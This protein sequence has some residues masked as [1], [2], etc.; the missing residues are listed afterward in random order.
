M[1]KFKNLIII[2]LSV[3]VIVGCT[4]NKET[5][6]KDGILSIGVIQFASHP[7][8]DQAFEGFKEGLSDL[9]LVEGEDFRIE[10]QNAQG[11]TATAE[12]I[13]DKLVNDKHDLIYAIAT[14]AAQ[15]V[16]SKTQT[17]PI[18]VA[19]VTDPESAGLVMSNDMPQT[20]VSGVSDLTPVKRQIELLKEIGPDV[21]KVAV[22]YA[23]SED[24]SRFQADIA[25]QEIE[26]L[27]MEFIDASVSDSNQVQTMAESLILKVDAIYVP[28]DNLVSESFSIVSKIANEHNI[29]TVVGEIA[30]VNSGGLITDG[31]S[32]FNS[33][34]R[35]SDL[36]HLILIENVDVSEIPVVFLTEEDLELAI[37]INTEK[38]LNISLSDELKAKAKIVE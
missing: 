32:Y 12:T 31:I 20:N 29:L 22:M 24:N 17:I 16:A 13:A 7:A 21:K 25:K 4:G 23:N 10:H 28:T 6:T 1:K 18:L 33:G 34:K 14:P 3:L 36:A 35:A 11:D 26:N 15:A 8:L 2:L 9:G 37:N 38:E 27:G 30:M 5:K 19:A